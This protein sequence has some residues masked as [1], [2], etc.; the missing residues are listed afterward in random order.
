MYLA[1]TETFW[2]EDGTD[3]DGVSMGR[4]SCAHTIQYNSTYT[5]AS[6]CHGNDRLPS[7]SLWIVALR[8][9]QFCGIVTSTDCI[10]HV[11]V[12]SHSE[13]FTTR[14]HRSNRHPSVEPWIISLH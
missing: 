2:C 6:R 11:E 13:V 7:I 10:D 5:T 12:D 4:E 8:T 1:V 14:T 3:G 9:T